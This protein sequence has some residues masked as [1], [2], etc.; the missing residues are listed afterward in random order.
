MANQKKHFIEK[1]PNCPYCDAPLGENPHLDH[2]QPVN[3]GGL[4]IS[5]NLV[6]CCSECNLSKSNKGLI[7]FLLSKEEINIELVCNRLLALG[8]R[9]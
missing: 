8:K 7:E 9:V 3:R 1:T 4:S 6:W 5:H 2:I